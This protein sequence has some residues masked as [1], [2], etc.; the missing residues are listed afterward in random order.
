MEIPHRRG[1]VCFLV[2]LL[3]SGFYSS[4][5]VLRSGDSQQCSAAKIFVCMRVSWQPM[6]L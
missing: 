4:E 5:L 2:W 3:S 1:M 6:G